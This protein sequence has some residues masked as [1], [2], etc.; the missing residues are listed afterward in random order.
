M[1]YV[2]LLPHAEFGLNDMGQYRD[3]HREDAPNF[4][5]YNHILDLSSLVDQKID[6]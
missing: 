3:D 5:S 2:S 6:F 4:T 1:A